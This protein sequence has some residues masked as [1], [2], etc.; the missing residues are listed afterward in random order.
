MP[1]HPIGALGIVSAPSARGVARRAAIRDSWPHILHPAFVVKFVLR[2]GGLAGVTHSTLMQEAGVICADSVSASETR[3]RGPILA[4]AW[5]LRFALAQWPYCR[6]ICK[7]DSDTWLVLPDLHH[8]LAGIIAHDRK[9]AGRFAYYGSFGFFSLVDVDRPVAR[10][11][12]RG[13]APRFD[14]A[15]KLLR[16]YVIPLCT[17]DNTSSARC[18]GPF[19]FAYGPIVALG[20]GIVEQLVAE[21]QFA[22][23][24]ERLP[25]LIPGD[26]SASSPT[27]EL[28]TEDVWLGSAL[29]RFVG[30]NAPLRL[31]MLSGEQ[32]WLYS[33]DHGLRVRPYIVAWHNRNKNLGRMKLLGLHYN[34]GHHC[35]IDPHWVFGE[36]HCCG[37]RHVA[38]AADFVLG[39]AVGRRAGRDDNPH[40]GRWPTFHIDPIYRTRGCGLNASTPVDLANATTLSRL[41]IARQLGPSTYVREEPLLRS[42]LRKRRRGARTR[43]TAI[44]REVTLDEEYWTHLYLWQ[45]EE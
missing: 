31:Y 11:V 35:P 6:F 43:T 9:D 29:W 19:P 42:R 21:R 17:Q 40:S 1:D 14:L 3:L 39:S 36:R 41:G 30:A 25:Q 22:D 33:D 23:E 45:K 18:A 32:R 4:L 37:K 5:W 8:Q 27:A 16:K 15:L 12:H 38:T 13:F 10:Y 26:A 28:A 20:R 34:L 7:A 24:I 2:C 44:E